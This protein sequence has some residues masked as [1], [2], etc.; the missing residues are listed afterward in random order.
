M[1]ALRS[2]SSFLSPYQAL[3]TTVLVILWIAFISALLLRVL[4]DEIDV[5]VDNK[6]RLF[7]GVIRNE[8]SNLV[9]AAVDQAMRNRRIA[10]LKQN[11][12]QTTSADQNR[13]QPS[14]TKDKLDV[15]ID[16]SRDE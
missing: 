3:A 16:T 7:Y 8:V 13:K 11:R 4:R 10:N 1:E 5:M 2:A 15:N 6:A 14:T 9:D 12:K